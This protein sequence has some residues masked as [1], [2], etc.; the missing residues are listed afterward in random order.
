MTGKEM[1]EALNH[2]EDEL[3]EEI[4]KDSNEQSVKNKSYNW[5]AIIIV[6]LV[7]VM[8]GTVVAVSRLDKFVFHGFSGG[9]TKG[10]MIEMDLNRFARHDFQGEVLEVEGFIRK[11]IAEYKPY[12][13]QLPQFWYG[14][15]E[16][17]EE[18]ANYLGLEAL[19]NLEWDID[20]KN[21]TLCIQGNNQGVFKSI[22]IESYYEDTDLRLQ[23]YAHI[24]TE[25]A[26]GDELSLSHITSQTH[27]A[28]TYTNENGNECMI[29]GSNLSKDG[30]VV[31]DGILYYVHVSY[32]PGQEKQAIDMLRSWLDRY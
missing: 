5:A 1:L 24:L 28:A 16:T 25:K 13:S 22:Y 7:C 32:Q 31:S 20:E 21:V 4:K 15:Y 19:K 6:A 10:Y 30:Y 17:F 18:A 12:M 26:D 29:V 2:I 9:Q 14:R 3:I 27:L 11:Q 23:G 8:S